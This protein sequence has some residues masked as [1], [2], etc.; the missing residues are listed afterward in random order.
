LSRFGLWLRLLLL[1]LSSM[2]GRFLALVLRLGRLHLLLLQLALPLSDEI[3]QS[4]AL[5]LV[6]GDDQRARL[7]PGVVDGGSLRVLRHVQ[8]VQGAVYGQGLGRVPALGVV[9][10]DGLGHVASRHGTGSSLLSRLCAAP[11]TD[12]DHVEL[13]PG[14]DGDQLAVVELDG[15]S[16]AGVTIDLDDAALSACLDRRVG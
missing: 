15:G 4:L 1:G 8:A 6:L 5:S 11:V 16:V 14:C 3:E 12:C 9:A 10:S 2:T 13:S 7:L